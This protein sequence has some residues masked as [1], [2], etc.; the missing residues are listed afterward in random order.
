MR[1]T[2]IVIVG[3]GLAGSLAACMLGRDGFDVVMVDPHA[4]Y[5]P[6]LRCE[7]LDG[8]Q[9]K[10]LHKTGFAPSVLKATTHDGE[11]WVARFGHLIDKKP[12]DQ[13]GIMYDTLV[14]TLRAEIPPRAECIFAKVNAVYTSRYRQR[15]TLNTGEDIAARL[16]VMANGL[17][18]GMRLALGMKREDLSPCHSITAGF[19]IKP[20]DRAAF[21][22]KAM[23]Y[24]PER[25]TDRMAYLSLFPIGSTM[26]ANLMVY[27][28]M[29]DPWLRK[30]R[31]E[32][33]AALL[34]AMPN[35]GK[36]TGA[37]ETVGT[38]KIRPADLYVTTRHQQPGVVLVG[39]AFSTSCP[40]AG[41]GAGKVF[42]DVERL[43]NIHIPRW[44]STPGMHEDKITQFYADPVKVAFDAECLAKAYRLR[45]LSVDRS[46]PWQARR[47]TKFVARS[48]VGALR[49]MAAPVAGGPSGH[50]PSAEQVR[51][52]LRRSA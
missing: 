14:N 20:L 42:N 5:P 34:E 32:P 52:E 41:A 28:D 39:D 35:L 37:F 24:Y 9:V 36:L 17:N 12:S 1:S 6:D 23:T 48:C 45:S 50:E 8:G 43:C 33:V 29:N 19:D 2:D 25:A 15:V 40:A 13:Q 22:F 18:T 51:A 11:A 31:L 30:L 10:I 21:D 38:I 4:V 46:M 27:R 3:G 47:L 49:Q 16:V 7:K 44:L 26:R